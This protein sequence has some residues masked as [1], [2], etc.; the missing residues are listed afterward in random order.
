MPAMCVETA[1]NVV[2]LVAY[3]K[4]DV[5]WKVAASVLRHVLFLWQSRGVSAHMFVFSN[6]QIVSL[7][8]NCEKEK[9]CHY[10]IVPELHNSSDGTL[11][12]LAAQILY[13]NAACTHLFHDMLVLRPPAHGESAAML[14]FAVVDRVAVAPSGHGTQKVAW[15]ISFHIQILV[16]FGDSLLALSSSQKCTLGGPATT[17]EP[18]RVKLNINGFS[19]VAPPARLGS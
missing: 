17:F 18:L 11:K 10:V 19:I 13:H 14:D 9:Y 3:N 8:D 15:V 7:Q 6:G 4:E 2:F 1:A 16:H 5:D 12:A